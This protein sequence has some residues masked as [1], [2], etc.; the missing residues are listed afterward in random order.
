[1]TVK[2]IDLLKCV[3]PMK[4]LCEKDNVGFL[5]ALAISKNVRE[6]DKALENYLSQKQLLNDK[7]LITGSGTQTIK[8]GLEEEYFHKVTELND[9]EITLPIQTIDANELAAITF[10]PKYVEGIAFMLDM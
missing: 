7:Y 3:T 5:T 1:M 10:P 6:I 2:N 8:S 4:L 9:R